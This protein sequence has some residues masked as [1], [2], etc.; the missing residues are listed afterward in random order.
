MQVYLAATDWWVSIRRKLR[1]KSTQS[2]W[3]D[4]PSW[5]KKKLLIWDCVTAKKV[6]ILTLRIFADV[7]LGLK[8]WNSVV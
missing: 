2:L 5:I 1:Y 7:L 3:S 6:Q 8:L 4:N